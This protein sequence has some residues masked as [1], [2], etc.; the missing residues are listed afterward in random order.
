MAIGA[1]QGEV[2]RA[3]DPGADLRGACAVYRE[4]C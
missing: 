1:A 3:G 2:E 4:R